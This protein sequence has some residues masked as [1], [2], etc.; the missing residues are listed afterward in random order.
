MTDSSDR[1]VV[2]LL[3]AILIL[4]L[5]L[6]GG[7]GA[8]AGAAFHAYNSFRK[9]TGVNQPG[10]LTASTVEELSK[11]QKEIAAILQQRANQAGKELAGQEKRRAELGKIPGGPL[12][13]ADFALTFIQLLSD[14]V[15]L[16][17]RQIVEI[18]QVAGQMIVPLTTPQ[19][20]DASP[21]WKRKDEAQRR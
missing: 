10:A 13:K 19:E 6:V 12:Q 11:R 14:Q 18:E 15:L 8:A 1:T 3:T 17:Q 9:E 16:L 21:Q 20:L 7:M 4:L 5:L 2:R